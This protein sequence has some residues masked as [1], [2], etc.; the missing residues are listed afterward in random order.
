MPNS[1]SSLALPVGAGLSILHKSFLNLVRTAVDLIMRGDVAVFF[2]TDFC[3]FTFFDTLG[4]SL[5]SLEFSLD[6]IA[7]GTASDLSG[8]STWLISF[9]SHMISRNSCFK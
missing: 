3:V 9:S 8:Y 5:S 6:G 4:S 1:V 7:A 2:T